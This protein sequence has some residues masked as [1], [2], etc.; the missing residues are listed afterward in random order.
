MISLYHIVIHSVYSIRTVSPF[1]CY[2]VMFHQFLCDVLRKN[3]RKTRKMNFEEKLLIFDE[4]FLCCVGFSPASF[5]CF[6]CDK[7][8]LHYLES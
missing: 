5:S 1:F 4:T 2:L 7:Q 8:L 6:S 3:E